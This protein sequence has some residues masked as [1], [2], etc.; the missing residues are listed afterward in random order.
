MNVKVGDE[1]VGVSDVLHRLDDLA[2][3]VGSKSSAVEV[4]GGGA[5][6]GVDCHVEDGLKDEKDE[7]G[8]ESPGE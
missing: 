6:L 3:P 2:G 1:T 5:R 4:D 7:E 8:V